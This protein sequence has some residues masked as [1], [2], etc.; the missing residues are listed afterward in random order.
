ML[1]GEIMEEYYAKI[2]EKEYLVPYEIVAVNASI[3]NKYIEE[4]TITLPIG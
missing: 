2:N 1:V 3:F 4:H